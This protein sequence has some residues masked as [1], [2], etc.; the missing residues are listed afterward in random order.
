MPIEITAP[1]E[2]SETTISAPIALPSIQIS[3]PIT[4]S[5]GVSVNSAALTTSEISISAPVTIPTV[6]ITAPITVPPAIS[7]G[8]GGSSPDGS[9]M[10]KTDYDPRVI[11]ADVFDL[12]NH[13]GLLEKQEV[14]IDGGLL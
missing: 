5:S 7:I 14:V 13:T 11:E 9:Y 3:A 1:I 6:Q 8:T 10:K 2:T 4:I 12:A